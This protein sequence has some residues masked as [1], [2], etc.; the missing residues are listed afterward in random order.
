MSKSII[1]KAGVIHEKKWNGKIR[2]DEV[3]VK[4]AQTLSDILQC[5]VELEDTTFEQFFR[6]VIAE[7][8]FFQKA[9][10]GALYGWSLDSYAEEIE[11]TPHPEDRSDDLDHVEV[12]W[13]AHLFEDELSLGP[14]FHG[15]GD[16]KREPWMGADA[17]AKGG[18]AIEFTPIHHYKHKLLK[19]D[20]EV[21]IQD[22]KD[23]EGKNVLKAKQGFTVYDVLN[24][25]LFEITWG[26]DVSHRDAQKKE[27]FDRADEAKRK[28]D[29]EKDGLR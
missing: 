25:I 16:W 5:P 11:K 2:Q 23:R 20:T 4:P 21:H 17:P 8:P 29:E 24:A 9:F 13:S 22:L 10:N 14:G 6:L 28:L 18:I 19:L 7:L 15:W 26:G 3:W 1:I 27:I 12:Y